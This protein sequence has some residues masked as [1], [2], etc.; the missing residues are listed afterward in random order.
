MAYTAGNLRAQINAPPGR[1]H[2]R[3]DT[4]D[5]P[6]LVEAANYFNN[7]DN[8]LN[9]QIGDR[10]D[11]FKWSD[12]PFAAGSLLQNAMML[13]VTNVIART[14]AVGPGRVNCA[15]VFLVTSLLSS[16]T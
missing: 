9:L 3:Y 10:I 12:T 5:H 1:G 11:V 7:K 2:Y 13:V 16:G 8:N 6:D 14:A 15:Q 4:T